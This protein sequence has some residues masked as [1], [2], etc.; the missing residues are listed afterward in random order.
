MP[1]YPWAGIALLTFGGLTEV[2]A[3][4]SIAYA[5]AHGM[6]GAAVFMGLC[7]A[8]IGCLWVVVFRGTREDW[9]PRIDY[10][11]RAAREEA[12]RAE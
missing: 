1:D 6:V 2:F 7:A 12:R 4:G 10:A 5:L 8:W 9:P 3:A 11:R